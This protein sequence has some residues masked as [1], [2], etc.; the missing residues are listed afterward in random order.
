VYVPGSRRVV[1]RR[2]SPLIGWLREGDTEA[3]PAHRHDSGCSGL[4]L[5]TSQAK[6][7]GSGAKALWTHLDAFLRAQVEAIVACDFVTVETIQLR[8]LSA[9]GGCSSPGSRLT[10]G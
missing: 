9:P 6:R 8:T 4:R 10:L 3:D 5:R 1:G 7:P 2:S